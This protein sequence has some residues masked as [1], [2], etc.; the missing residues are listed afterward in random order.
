M[1][2]IAQYVLV[3][4]LDLGLPGAAI[5]TTFTNICMGLFLF[6]YIRVKKLYVQT[7]TGFS[8]EAF[9]EWK[10]YIFLAFPG[11]LML[12]F[13]KTQTLLLFSFFFSY[14]LLFQ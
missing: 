13:I 8:R 9:K 3:R 7:W 4:V 1:N 12:Y 5:G 14:Y 11:A 2:A 6:T 10:Q